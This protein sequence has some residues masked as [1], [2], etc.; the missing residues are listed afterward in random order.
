MDVRAVFELPVHIWVMREALGG[1][2]PT[3]FGQLRFTVLTPTDGPP[4]DESPT[5]GPPAIEGIESHPEL[6]GADVEWAQQ[7]GAFI[8]ESLKPA[9]ALLRI[10]VTDVDGP[11]YDHMSWFTPEHQL[12]EYVTPWFDNARTWV[13]VFTGQDLD[14]NHRVY[15][16]QAVGAGLTFIEP[17]NDSALGL[18]IS[19]PRILPLPAEQWARILAFVRDGVEPPLEEVLSRD[20]RAAQRRGADRR[21]II[22]SATAL[23]IVLGRHVRGLVDQLPESQ[24]KRIG[25]RAALGTYISIAKES[26]LELAVDVEK[27]GWLNNL[28]HD[29]VHRGL[30]PSNWDAGTA[31]QLMIDFLGAHGHIRHTGDHEPDGS[32]WIVADLE[33][34]DTAGS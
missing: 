9:T 20:A 29:A 34:E 1:T 10:G 28:R 5:T 32:E 14:P 2:Y 7:Y 18:Q 8:P 16:A 6:S 24:Q 22:D 21:A 33:P 31:V 15:D 23:E 26:G 30:A 11:T 25:E 4:V 17:P 3:G 12:A 13:E 27:L 19:T